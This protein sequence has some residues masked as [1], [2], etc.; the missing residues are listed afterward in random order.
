MNHIISIMSE[1]FLIGVSF[2]LGAFIST[3]ILIPFEENLIKF[4][5]HRWWL[6]KGK[7]IRGTKVSGYF[8]DREM[9]R[10]VYRDNP[11]DFIF[12]G[13][14]TEHFKMYFEL[15]VP[16]KNLKESPEMSIKQSDDIIRSAY[17]N[18][19]K[20]NVYDKSTFEINHVSLKSDIVIRME[21][22]N[23]KPPA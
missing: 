8:L 22:L 5:R 17:L 23:L 11:S 15:Y 21:D 20:I 13:S 3:I 12:K 18:K 9:R 1:Y 16:Y 6:M 4:L 10:R 2:I 7:A 14:P 19:Y